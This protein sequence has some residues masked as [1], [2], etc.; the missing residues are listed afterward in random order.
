MNAVLDGPVLR[1]A[2]ILDAPLLAAVERACF[3]PPWS[4]AQLAAELRGPGA[5]GLIADAPAGDGG[6]DRDGNA[7]GYALFRHVAGEAELL[8]LAVLPA[9]RRRGVAQRLLRA[10]LH[11][12]RAAGC[13][14]AFLE[15]SERNVPAVRLYQREGWRLDGRRPAYYP[16]G[17]A[18]LLYRREP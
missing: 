7:A 16:D 4:E 9:V 3:A 14:A 5:L 6:E 8:R 1:R 17:S 10:G 13:T 2:R 12:L 18:A 15:V 11:E